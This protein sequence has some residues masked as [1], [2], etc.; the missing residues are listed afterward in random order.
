M[1]LWA[2]EQRP[3]AGNERRDA[4][5]RKRVWGEAYTKPGCRKSSIELGELGWRKELDSATSVG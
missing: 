1:R 2:E 5:R 3:E 4:H